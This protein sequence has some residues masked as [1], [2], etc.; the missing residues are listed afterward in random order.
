MALEKVYVKNF[1]QCILG[2]EM[3]QHKNKPTTCSIRVESVL[4]CVNGSSKKRYTDSQEY[5]A[6]IDDLVG[7]HLFLRAHVSS[8]ACGFSLLLIPKM[9]FPFV[10]G[11][12]GFHQFYDVSLQL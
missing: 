4:H 12:C 10:T 2:V 8:V 1:N 6:H 7:V 11:K 5:S 9:L 3:S